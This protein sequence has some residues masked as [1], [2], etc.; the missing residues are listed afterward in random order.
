M[1]LATPSDNLQLP[2]PPVLPL[3]L[4]LRAMLELAAPIWEPFIF[5]TSR[6]R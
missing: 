6:G 1:A 5:D 3:P 4:A 2:W